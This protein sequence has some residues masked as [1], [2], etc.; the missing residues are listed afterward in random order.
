MFEENV[1]E[2]LNGRKFEYVKM[3]SPTT[4]CVWEHFPVKQDWKAEHIH[5]YGILDVKNVDV[6]SLKKIG[7]WDN[8]ALEVQKDIVEGITQQTKDVKD[9]MEK[10][11]SSRKDKYVNVPRFLYCTLC[12]KKTPISPGVLVKK[13]EKIALVK[14][15]TYTLDIFLKEYACKECS[16]VRRGRAANPEFVNL[17]KFMIC[18]CGA[19]V[20]TNPN[21]LKK[22]AKK[23]GTTILE[24]IKNYSC[25]LCTPTKLGGRKGRKANPE[26]ANIPKTATCVICK[27][28]VI[29]SPPNIIGKA[30][31]LKITVEELIKGYKCRSCG[32]RLSKGLKK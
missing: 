12:H 4:M 25:Q 5:K 32:G 29:I 31:I 17:P 3:H 14:G 1:F 30:K 26:F 7:V 22:K 8:L 15:I 11:R 10:A 21:Q 9:L 20:A 13:V 19:K 24:L 16:P 28:S 23:E 6:D 18:K 2:A 27:K